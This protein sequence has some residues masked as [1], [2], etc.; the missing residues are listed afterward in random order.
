MT[1]ITDVLYRLRNM[2]GIAADDLRAAVLEAQAVLD[3][4]D[5]FADAAQDGAELIAASDL[6]PNSHA[7]IPERSGLVRTTSN[8]P[9]HRLAEDHNADPVCECGWN[10]ANHHKDIGTRDFGRYLVREHIQHRAN[11]DCIQADNHRGTCTV[12]A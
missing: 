6:E 3:K 1:D 11:P 4:L 9:G 7:S 8:A 10:P 5:R 12:M 2:A